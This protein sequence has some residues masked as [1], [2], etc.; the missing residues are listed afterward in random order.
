MVNAYGKGWVS[1]R[2]AFPRKDG[3]ADESERDILHNSSR[4]LSV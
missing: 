4:V 3:F 2:L 1:G